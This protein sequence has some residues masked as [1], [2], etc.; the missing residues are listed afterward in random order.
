M[1]GLVS[2]SSR[3]F[4]PLTRWIAAKKWP[5][6]WHHLFTIATIAKLHITC[7]HLQ[8]LSLSTLSI[9][10]TKVHLACEKLKPLPARC[11]IQHSVLIKH[12]LRI[13]YDGENPWRQRESLA[14]RK[15]HVHSRQRESLKL[16]VNPSDRQFSMHPQSSIQH[17]PVVNSQFN[18][19]SQFLVHRAILNCAVRIPLCHRPAPTTTRRLT[20]QHE[21]SW[22][23]QKADR[24]NSTSWYSTTG[25]VSKRIEF[26]VNP[27]FVVNPRFSIHC[28]YPI[29]RQFSVRQFVVNSQ[30]IVKPQFIENPGFIVNPRF[31]EEDDIYSESLDVSTSSC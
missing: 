26:I 3:F 25:E 15:S 10:T 5:Q 30:F 28:E 1:D 23:Q 20:T 17:Q 14:Q 16:I 21:R 11:C 12:V 9:V 19:N 6:Q 18:V 7:P 24:S 22:R 31:V 29:H 4:N 2:A 13:P 8:S 27:Q